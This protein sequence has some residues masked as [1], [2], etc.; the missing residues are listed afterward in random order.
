[1]SDKNTQ[2]DFLG[3]TFKYNIKWK[4]KPHV[5]YTRHAGSRGIALY[6]IKKKCIVLLLKLNLYLK[7]QI[8]WMPII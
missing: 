3:Y 6:P 5:F 4:M 2:L 8:I 7:N 1:M